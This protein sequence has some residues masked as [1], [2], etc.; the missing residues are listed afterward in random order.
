MVTMMLQR[1][2]LRDVLI[3]PVIQSKI[4]KV[5]IPNGGKIYYGAEMLNFLNKNAWD[6]SLTKLIF[7]KTILPKH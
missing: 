7:K 3:S 1:R 6:N 4:V 5:Y 2:S